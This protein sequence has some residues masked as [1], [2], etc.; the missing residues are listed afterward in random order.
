[1]VMTDEV[2]DAEAVGR[3]LGIHPRTVIRLAKDKKLPGFRVGGQWR[4]R[5][6][7]IE[8]YI[9]RQEREGMGADREKD[10]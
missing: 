10:E 7:T 2:L 9:K 4:F 5:R 8:E 3:M 1:M 6:E